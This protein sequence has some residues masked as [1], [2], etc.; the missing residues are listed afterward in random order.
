M[1]DPPSR[2][3]HDP[4]AGAL[5]FCTAWIFWQMRGVCCGGPDRGEPSETD[6]QRRHH[7]DTLPW[8]K[9]PAL[10]ESKAPVLP[11]CRRW[12]QNTRRWW[13]RLWVKPHAAMWDPSGSPLWALA[14]LYNDMIS[15]PR[16]AASVSA[17]IRQHELGIGA[18]DAS[19]E[20]SHREAPPGH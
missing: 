20:G 4:Q 11:S 18:P 16:D 19:G 2:V 13:T 8:I 10:R 3:C 7:G 6:G 9:L 17:E 5:G 12:H 14:A 1:I 15:G